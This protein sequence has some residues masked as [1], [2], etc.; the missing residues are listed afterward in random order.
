MWSV[1]IIEGVGSHT[2]ILELAEHFRV[3]LQGKHLFGTKSASRRHIF[4][5]KDKIFD[6]F[7]E[8]TVANRPLMSREGYFSPFHLS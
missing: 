2:V 8:E 6:Y 1:V 3:R 5:I 4:Q 7:R